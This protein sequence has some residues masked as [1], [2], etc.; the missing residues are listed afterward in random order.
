MS[1]LFLEQQREE[2]RLLSS[3]PLADRVGAFQGANYDAKAYYRSQ[4]DCI[5]FTRNAVPFCAVCRKA[6]ERVISL[7]AN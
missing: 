4:A 2:T 3:F 1:A 5:M 7:Y 6:L